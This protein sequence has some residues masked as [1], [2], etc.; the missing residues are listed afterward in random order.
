MKLVDLRRYTIRKQSQIRFRLRND[1]ECVITDSGMAQV[2]ALKGIPDFNLE[3]EFASAAE[4]L[5]ESTVVQK[6]PAK[7][8]SLKRDELAKLVAGS[9]TAAAAP[10][11]DDE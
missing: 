8:Q 7:P 11:H 10:E 1:L 5:V 6:N 3:E 4:F 2:P 9:P